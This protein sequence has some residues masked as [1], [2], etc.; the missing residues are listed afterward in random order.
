M[1]MPKET[2][3]ITLPRRPQRTTEIP[4]IHTYTISRE[5]SPLPNKHLSCILCNKTLGISNTEHHCE[6]RP[7]EEFSIK[8]T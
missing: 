7:V 6:I 2:E 8:F 1:S 4:I 3:S 5:F